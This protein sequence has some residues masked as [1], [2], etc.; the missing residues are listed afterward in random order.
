M[1]WDVEFH[2]GFEAEFLAFEQTVQDA[3]LVV[4][5]LLADYGP[6]PCGHAQGLEARQYEGAAVRG[7]GW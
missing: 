3:L 6:Q 5:K 4:A 2:D 7:F 1:V